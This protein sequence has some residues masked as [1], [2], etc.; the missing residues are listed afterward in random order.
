MTIW[1]CDGKHDIDLDALSNEE[2][3]RMEELINYN[4]IR[5]CPE[6][7][8]LAP[9]QQY[10]RFSV[11]Y[12]EDVQLS[13]TG[14]CNF[15]CK[16][17]FQSAPIGK[18]GTISLEQLLHFADEMAAC[19]IRKVGFTGGEPL[20]RK[21]FWEVFDGFTQRGIF[22]NSIFTNG[23]LVNEEWLDQLDRRVKE[24]VR[25]PAINVS[26]DGVGCH[27][28]LRGVEGAEEAV[29][30][31]MKLLHARGYAVSVSMCLHRK[32]TQSLRETV[33]LLYELGVDSLKVN[34]TRPE[35]EWLHET[36]NCL[37]TQEGWEVYLD[38]LPH[39]YEDGARLSLMLEGCFNTN[40]NSLQWNAV[41]DHYCGEGWENRLSCGVLRR[42]FYISPQGAVVPCMSLAGTYAEELFPNM[43]TSS[44]HDILQPDTSFIKLS[45]ITAGQIGQANPECRECEHLPKCWGGCRA[46]GANTSD[47]YEGYDKYACDWHKGNW[48]PRFEQAVEAGLA[49]MDPARRAECEEHD[50]K[51]AEHI[52]E[53][54][55]LGNMMIKQDDSAS[56]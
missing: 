43:N 29:I 18:M 24:G 28:W 35:G 42:H 13:I 3:I 56:C 39:Y 52:E 48:L 9:H 41:N 5:E 54:Q 27:D 32:N 21:D 31:A 25:K 1:R 16:H 50:R 8:E 14:L 55:R 7:G 45:E 15:K 30:N 17:C 49:L 2:R 33:N 22:V 44:L 40:G 53:K 11:K 47:F 10:R 51:L 26:F 20:I 12:R 37:S 36:Q 23:W 38:Y 34:I 46:C 6:G 4:I 19:G